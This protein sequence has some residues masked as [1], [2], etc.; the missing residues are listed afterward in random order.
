MKKVL[1]CLCLVFAV[2]LTGCGGKVELNLEDLATKIDNLSSGSFAR[3]DASDLLD[4]EIP[5]L[6]MVYDFDYQEKFGL[7]PDNLEET[8]V[9][10]NEETKDMYFIVKPME[11]KK[12]TVKSEIDKYIDSLDANIKEKESFEEFQGYLIY[13]ISDNSKDLLKEIK[14]CESKLFNNLMDGGEDSLVNKYGIEKDL[15][16]EYLI[17]EPMIITSAN[18]YVILK[19]VEGKKDEVI[20]KMDEYMGKLE[21]QWSTYLP[22]Q[23]DLVKDRLKEEYGD[24]VIYVVS[25]DNDLVFKTIKDN[26]LA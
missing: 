21:E 4:Q 19:P 22:D 20:K 8:L 7:N 26:N 2:V 9:A 1:L 17:R 18:T 11:G 10:V 12:D 24:Y 25:K 5:G 14:K 6:V 23:Y 3:L 16:E 13:I 15:V